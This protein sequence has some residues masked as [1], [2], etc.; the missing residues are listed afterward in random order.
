MDIIALLFLVE[1]GILPNNAW[2]MYENQVVRPDAL[3]YYTR[4]HAEI[5]LAE[6]FFIGGAV[7]TRMEADQLQP[8]SF[9]PY[10]DEFLFTLGFRWGVMEVGFRH[11]CTHPI[12]PYIAVSNPEVITYEGS[13][14]EVYV[15]FKLSTQ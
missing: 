5:E 10:T 9:Y 4:L 12:I 13:Y 2:L 6:V 3:Q 8:G 15:R 14:E 1:V 7:T 11:L